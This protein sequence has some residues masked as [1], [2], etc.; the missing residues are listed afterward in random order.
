MLQCNMIYSLHV[1]LGLED[2]LADL[3]YARKHDKLGRLAL[4]AYCDVKGWARLANKPELADTAL[5]MF[6]ENPCVSK[7]EFLQSIDRLIATLELHEHAFQKNKAR[8][9]AAAQGESSLR[10]HH[11]T[12]TS[13]AST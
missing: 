11:Q 7:M 6:S 12:Q 2:L 5:Q 3:R 4:L 13:M 9:D 10:T 8:S 1:Q